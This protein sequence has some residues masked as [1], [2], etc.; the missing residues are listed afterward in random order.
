MKIQCDCGKF[1]A[2]LAEF[3]KNSPGRV[4]CYCDDCQS[5]LQKIQ[6][7]ELLDPHGGTE[8][9]PVYPCDMEFTQGAEY[10]K[11]YKLSPKGLSRWATDC[12][13]SPIANTRA[14]F[15][16]VG[17]FHRAFTREDPDY[18][19]KLGPIRS[20]I[21]GKYAK[22]KPPFKVPE[23]MGFKVLYSVMPFILKGKIFKKDKNSQF[24]EP[25]GKIP[26]SEPVLF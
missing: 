11:C 24:Y 21:M 5:F 16:W 9:V 25:D 18:L 8:L 2:K 4:V 22:S 6:R 3:P 19:Q 20:R 13:G 14:H 1:K 12:C 23:K 15:P 7:E 17:I 26:I 10:L